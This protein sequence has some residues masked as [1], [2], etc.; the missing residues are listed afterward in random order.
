V[1][2]RNTVL[3]VGGALVMLAVIGAIYLEI[4]VQSRSTH[5]VWMVTQQVPAGSRFSVDNVRRV[6]VP[7][8]G[9]RILYFGRNPIST[10]VRAGHT[11]AAGH[12]VAD[13]DL[14][15]RDTVLVPVSFKSAPPLG[16]GDKVDVYT[17]LGTKTVQVGK[18]LAVESPTTIWV[19]AVDEPNWITLQA[20][21]A[22]LFAAT[23]TGIGVPAAAGI[24]LPD[25]VSALAGSV[26]GGQSTGAQSA[27]VL[28]PA[29]LTPA[30]PTPTPSP[31]QS[32]P[33]PRPSPSR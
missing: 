13:D 22:P 10:G 18:N 31:P 9:D 2:A 25:A 32:S 33:T 7:D 23:S 4:V 24:G 17:L 19:P 11:L 26:A 12:L 29:P 15:Q 16:H 8:T 30:S 3:Y 5:S 1:N 20:N 21:N 6:D 14:L 27:P 28:T